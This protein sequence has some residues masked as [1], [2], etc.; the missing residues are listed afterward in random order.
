VRWLGGRVSRER[1]VVWRKW[2]VVGAEN[3][4]SRS[5]RLSCGC[6]TPTVMARSCLAHVQCYQR[7]ARLEQRL[8]PWIH[9]D[10]RRPS[11][12]RGH[13]T[14]PRRQRLDAYVNSQGVGTKIAL[15]YRWRAMSGKP[16]NE[17]GATGGGIREDRYQI[18]QEPATIVVSNRVRT[19]TGSRDQA[20]RVRMRM[21]NGRWHRAEIASNKELA[22]MRVYGKNVAELSQGVQAGKCYG[23]RRRLLQR[24]PR[25]V[26]IQAIGCISDAVLRQQGSTVARAVI[27][28]CSAV[29][30][31]KGRISQLQAG[32]LCWCATSQLCAA[33]HARSGL[34][35]LKRHNEEAQE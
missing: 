11:N 33:G 7:P 19:V 15:E 16:R 5:A 1:A 13:V 9:D 30:S 24:Q 29:W 34:S 8:Q 32:M 20:S 18:N 28:R 6:P 3:M 27:A 23:V 2:A 17:G 35:Y 10:V 26:G 21:A 14:Q 4:P 31:V 25:Y 12:L 22:G